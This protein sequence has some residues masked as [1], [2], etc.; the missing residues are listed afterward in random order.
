VEIPAVAAQHCVA[1]VGGRGAAGRRLGGGAVVAVRSTAAS[2]KLT[3]RASGQASMLDRWRTRLAVSEYDGKSAD[4]CDLN[5]RLDLAEPG[6]TAVL[7]ARAYRVDVRHAIE[8]AAPRSDSLA[9]RA[10]AADTGTRRSPTA[11]VTR[12]PAS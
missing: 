7:A 5:S 9:D 3:I 2:V 1:S 10:R 4:R 8:P 12:P 11:P 6:P